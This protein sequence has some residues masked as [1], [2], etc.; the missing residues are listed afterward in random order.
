MNNFV[1]R[2]KIPNRLVSDITGGPNFQRKRTNFGILGPKEALEG[3]ENL[4]N[5]SGTIDYPYFDPSNTFLAL[6]GAKQ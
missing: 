6:L 4:K 2:Q 3:S 1:K 5:G